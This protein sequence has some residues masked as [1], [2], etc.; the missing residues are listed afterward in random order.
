VV[1]SAKQYY[2]SKISLAFLKALRFSAVTRRHFGQS[3]V[4]C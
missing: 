4:F 2:L 1:L 3:S